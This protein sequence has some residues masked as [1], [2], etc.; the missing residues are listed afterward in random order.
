M[1]SSSSESLHERCVGLG[2]SSRSVTLAVLE[3]VARLPGTGSAGSQS[4]L[5]LLWADHSVLHCIN[6]RQDRQAAR[7]GA[8]VL[9]TTPERRGAFHAAAVGALYLHIHV[10]NFIVPSDLL[11]RHGAQ[12]FE[13]LSL[14]QSPR[15]PSAAYF[16]PCQM[17][18]IVKAVHLHP[19][20]CKTP[21]SMRARE[22][23]EPPVCSLREAP[24]AP[25]ARSSTTPQQ[26][27]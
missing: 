11:K 6:A 10:A 18:V 20:A 23:R 19:R 12:F 26:S 15:P 5:L 9:V 3:P 24:W 27:G 2:G 22:N 17:P 13:Q 21:R 16:P 4:I 25:L 7:M 14:T 1:C 8:W